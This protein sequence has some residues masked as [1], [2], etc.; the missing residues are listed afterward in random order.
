VIILEDILKTVETDVT[1]KK[2]QIGIHWTA[3]VSNGCG[4]ASALC[5]PPP[6]HD[7]QVRD[8]GRLHEKS[9]S[10][11]AR[12][13]LSDRLLE[14]SIGLATINS[15]IDID[16]K[17]C[18]TINAFDILVERG[19]NK[20]IGI[21]GHFPFTAKLKQEARQLWIFEKRLQEGDLPEH[22]IEKLLPKCDVIGIS[23][24]TLINHTL[25]NILKFCRNDAFKIMLGAS[26][27]ML[28]LLFDYGLDVLA[29]CKV[30]NPDSVFTSISQGATFKQIKGI[31]L[32]SMRSR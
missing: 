19:K 28:S 29:G 10:D 11:L 32:L 20:N 25:E 22:E 9:V 8:V 2:V 26:T 27:P 15:L 17:K 16:E 13:V 23:A 7:N 4:L 6:H 3:V 1:I 18:E 31:K 12:N 5:E 24:T 21:I 30:I 14:A